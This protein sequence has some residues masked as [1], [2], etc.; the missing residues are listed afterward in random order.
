VSRKAALIVLERAEPGRELGLVRALLEADTRDAG[1]PDGAV[2]AAR[3]TGE[4]AA[5]GRWQRA[6]RSGAPRE[7]RRLGGGRS[8]P[9]GDGIVSL[10]AIAPAPCA[11]LDEP[12]PLPGPRLLNRWVR[13]LLAGLGAI[14]APASYPGRDFVCV[15]GRSAALLSLERGASGRLLFQAVIGARRDCVTAEPAPRFP[16][17][18]A[19]PEPTSLAAEGADPDALRE[20]AAG[21][22]RR[23]G[24]ELVERLELPRSFPPEPVEERPAGVSAGPVAVPIGELEAFVELAADGTL[25][26]VSLRGDWIAGSVDVA[27]LEGA[28]AGR[29]AGDP[30]LEALVQRWLALPDTLAVGV[31]D[32]RLIAEAVRRSAAAAEQ[33]AGV[34]GGAGR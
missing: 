8:T 30:Q 27:R 28:L 6:G 11:W 23:W 2:V 19:L 33:A 29:W 34:R 13:G 31:P 12:G 3:L 5:L 7:L 26:R 17:L 20:L 10:C 9:Y 25:G 4:A 18:P 21:C 16:G 24:V 22:A 14:G 15:R 1:A 32:A